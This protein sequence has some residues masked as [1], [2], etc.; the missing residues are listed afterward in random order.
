[1][2]VVPARLV[3][4]VFP[5]YCAVTVIR[6]EAQGREI[7]SWS[8]G[9]LQEGEA[10]ARPGEFRE[11]AS[12][13]N[14]DDQ[15]STRYSRLSTLTTLSFSSPPSLSHSTVN[16]T[17]HLTNHRP[18]Y[19]HDDQSEANNSLP[20]AIPNDTDRARTHS[21]AFPASPGGELRRN[22][23]PEGRP[24]TPDT[25]GCHPGPLIGQD[26]PLA[27]APSGGNFY[28]ERTAS[29]NKQLT[30]VSAVTLGQ[31]DDGGFCKRYED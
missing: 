25:A 26:P 12:P 16:A 8:Q 22:L 14:C 29:V 24:R 31:S 4:D 21:S 28:R 20:S 15:T 11:G 6:A 18:G 13:G 3:A 27:P 1:M 17:F 9:R 10:A 2:P 5:I 30:T 23:R 19:C 7:S